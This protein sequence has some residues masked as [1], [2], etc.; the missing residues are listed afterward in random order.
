MDR[1]ALGTCMGRDQGDRGHG[2]VGGAAVSMP[3]KKAH[4]SAYALRRHPTLCKRCSAIEAM[5]GHLKREYKLGRMTSRGVQE[6]RI[7]PY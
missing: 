3:G 4:A 2:P 5:I 1:P 7:T 6:I